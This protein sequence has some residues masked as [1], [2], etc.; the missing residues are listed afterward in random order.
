MPSPRFSVIIATYNGQAYLKGCLATVFKTD[1]P[2]FEV[3]VVDDGSTDGSL[4]LINK[5]T[6]RKELVLLKNKQNLGLVNSRNKAM[7]KST[8]QIL[9]FLDN[10]TEVDKA[11]LKGLAVVF[12]NDKSIGAAQCKMFDVKNRNVIQQAGMKLIPLTG[13]GVTLGRGQTDRFNDQIEI[14]ALGAAMA[15]RKDVAQTI[16]G[17]DK[18]LF[19]YCDD[20]DFSWRVWIA[21]FRVVLAPKSKIYHHLKVHPPTAKL[22]FHLAKNSA[23]MM[24]KNYQLANSLKFLPTSVFFSIAGAVNILLSR[25]SWVGVLGVVTGLV[26]S[27]YYLPDTLAQRK[28]IQAFRKVNDQYLFKTIMVP[29]N[30]PS[31]MKQYFQ[32]SRVTLR[33]MRNY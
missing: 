11:W 6:N 8:G 7:T 2:N 26:W 18:K 29:I 19:H 32:G 23:R 30:I 20:L 33:L 12:S 13:F 5:Y 27:F 21:G 9:V 24:I 22:Y 17:F 4:E 16:G 3:I 28:K 15:V 31:I 1:Y 10:D 25:G 14:V